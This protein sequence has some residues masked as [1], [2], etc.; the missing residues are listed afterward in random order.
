[1]YPIISFFLVC[2]V[3]MAGLIR[4]ASM[5]RAAEEFPRP[6]NNTGRSTHFLS[7]HP[8]NP[9]YFLWCDR[10]TILISSGEHYGAVLNRSFDYKKYLDT[11]ASYGFNHTR[12][13]CGLYVE[14][15]GSTH[16]GPQCGNTLDPPEG[17]LLCPF[18]RSDV[19]GYP[20][21][22]NKFDLSRWNTAFFARLRDC[23]DYA[24]ERRIIVEVNFFCPYYGD[25]IRQWTLSPFN[26]VNNVNGVGRCES[27]AVFTLDL[28]DGLLPF[29][30]AMVRRIV[31]HLQESENVYYEICNEPYLDGISPEWQHHIAEVI[32]H[33]E[34]GFRQKHLISQNIANGKQEK[35]IS[36]PHSAVSLFN[37][38]Y[39]S[40]DAVTMN[41][42]LNMPIGDNETGFI[43]IADAP[44]RREAWKF[45]TAGGALFSHLDYSFT[46]GHEDGSFVIPTRQGGGGGPF[47]RNQLQYLQQF[48]GRFDF[49]QM[50]PDH[51][52]IQGLTV[53]SRLNPAEAPTATKTSAVS[54]WALVQPG[55]QYAIYIDGGGQTTFQLVLPAGKYQAQWLHPRTGEY[56]DHMVFDHEG[57]YRHFVA[58]RYEVDIALRVYHT[59]DSVR[60]R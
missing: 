37:F 29:Q 1:M 17:Q 32:S 36:D 5:G 38:H 18:A 47:I 39:S 22:G 19:P 50:R 16:E 24:A 4:S 30:E 26:S 34:K 6:Q 23:V 12:I 60:S 59:E 33:T 56:A 2:F 31:E 53:E 14:D 58:P 21:G 8:L 51:S 48:L 46:V 13:F 41:Y 20:K 49:L 57:G 45:L 3:S 52:V 40:P 35:P 9:H 10:P 7:R 54:A 42:E 11:L 44:Y 15:N 25:E 43:G 27:K 28:H 55:R